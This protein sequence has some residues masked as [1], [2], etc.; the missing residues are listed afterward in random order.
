MFYNEK[1]LS[2]RLPD[3][4]IFRLIDYQLIQLIDYPIN[5]LNYAAHSRFAETYGAHRY[6]KMYL[7]K[8][9]KLLVKIYLIY[10]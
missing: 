3:Q 9:K 8:N 1:D 10:R 6:R 4:S 7:N 2:N 5:R